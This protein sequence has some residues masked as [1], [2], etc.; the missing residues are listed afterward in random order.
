MT[1]KGVLAQRFKN[2]FR[3]DSSEKRLELLKWKGRS[4]VERAAATLPH[5]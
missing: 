5:L 3:A 4:L 1:V 2:I